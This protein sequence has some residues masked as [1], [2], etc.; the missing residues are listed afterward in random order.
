MKKA[1]N[2]KFD[3]GII[4]GGPA[5]YVAA[6]RAAQL[7]AK[8]AVVEA[9]ELGGT[10]L[11]RGCI[12]SKAL[13]RCVEVIEL[14][15]S[16]RRMGLN[17]AEPEIDFDRVRQHTTRAVK[18]LVSGVET[19]MESND[20]TVIR[21]HGKLLAPT[22]VEVSGDE[23]AVQFE[24][25]NIIL[26]TGSVP[27]IPPIPGADSQRVIDSDQAVSL[28]GPPETLA[29]IGA[30]AVGSELAQVYA[31]FGTQV[32]LI[33]MLDRVV[34]TEDPEASALL[35]RAM[36]KQGIQVLTKSKVE[37]IEQ[38]DGG[39]RL[40]LAGQQETCEV[41]M[42]LMATSRQA[43]TDELGLDQLGITTERGCIVVDERMQTNIEGIYAA[44]DVRRG[45]GLAHLASHEGIVAVENALG[46]N[47]EETINYDA[48]PAVIYTH[49]EIASVGVQEHEIAE[50]DQ[51]CSV[52]TFPY[53]ANGRAA[54]YGERQGFVK[55]ITD[56][57]SG[58]VVGGTIAGLFASELIPEI[59]LSV[60]LGL[61]AEDIAET[62]HSH[63]TVSETI[64]EAA[65]DNL[66]RAVHLP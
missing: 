17:F 56:S 6:I 10:C 5:G 7:G 4:G 58:V 59:T 47:E 15:K 36:K 64:A 44:G 21:G 18:M 25:D 19:L 24:A 40:E 50:Y 61:R 35:E 49:P 27:F 26:C 28:P 8:T 11:N 13:L 31:A 39:L 2:D 22:Q 30:G 42:I 62:I 1:D 34:P 16:A 9:R 37:A 43:Y 63:P 65:L 45:V 20:I 54:A 60:R 29:V 53:S 46:C 48:V 12:P 33:E 23:Q 32:T 55:L 66:G 51:D 38:V 57:A 14:T 41:A 3:I 52:G